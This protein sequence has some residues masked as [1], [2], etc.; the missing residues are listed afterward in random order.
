MNK[1]GIDSTARIPA[2]VMQR[3]RVTES[4]LVRARVVPL[5]AP[6]DSI[7]CDLLVTGSDGPPRYLP[8]EHV[9]VWQPS[10]CDR[11]VVLGRIVVA[12]HQPPLE[13]PSEQIDMPDELVI[14][15]RKLLTLRVGDGSIT[16][17]EDGKILIKGKDLV[18]HAKRLNRI[19]GGSVAIN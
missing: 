5:E 7:E 15:V 10:P 8:G 1:L 14:E 4:D 3:G 12:E 11:G 17:S 2:A 16:I 6:E 13:R 19:R 9:L 18:S